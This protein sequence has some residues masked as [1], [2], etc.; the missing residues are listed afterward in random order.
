MHATMAVASGGEHRVVDGATHQFLH[1]SSRP[2]REAAVTAEILTLHSKGD[3]ERI[4]VT[5]VGTNSAGA[6]V[7]GRA[8]ARSGL[9]RNA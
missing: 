7:R 2:T 9:T 8:T 4:S 3:S 5:L 1:R 6:L